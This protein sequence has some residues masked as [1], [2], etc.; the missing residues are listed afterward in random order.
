MTRPWLAMQDHLSGALIERL[1]LIKKLSTKGSGSLNG[2]WSSCNLFLSTPSFQFSGKGLILS[3]IPSD[4]EYWGDDLKITCTIHHH[5]ALGLQW[6][7]WAQSWNMRWN[8]TSGQHFC[9]VG[10]SRRSWRQF[11]AAQCPSTWRNHREHPD[12]GCIM[13]SRR[14]LNK[15]FRRT[16][17]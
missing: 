15:I 11:Y 16:L 9:Q 8:K 1:A 14:W 17:S 5:M 4:T 3:S 7:T 2:K 6:W 10:T 13:N 12:T